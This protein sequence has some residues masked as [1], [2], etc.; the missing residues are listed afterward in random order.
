MKAIAT[1]PT[2]AP[3]DAAFATAPAVKF[4][5]A[6]VGAPVPEGRSVEVVTLVTYGAL[7]SIK[8]AQVMRVLLAK[9]KTTDRFPRKAPRPALVEAYRSTYLNSD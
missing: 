1:P 9:W 6:K 8:L 4:G 7:D 5:S 2:M 3:K